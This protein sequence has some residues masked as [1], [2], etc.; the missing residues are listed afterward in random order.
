MTEFFKSIESYPSE[1]ID[2][3]L[4]AS[5]CTATSSGGD[6]KDTRKVISSDKYKSYNDVEQKL[7]AI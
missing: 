7:M 3:I 6:S 5:V 4:T 2:D 1:M